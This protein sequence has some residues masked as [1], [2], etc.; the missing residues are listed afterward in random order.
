MVWNYIV[1]NK[2][3]LSGVIATVVM[4]VIGIWLGGKV[5]KKK[6]IKNVI[7]IKNS[8]VEKNE[9]DNAKYTFNG[10]SQYN[11]ADV[12][13]INNDFRKLGDENDEI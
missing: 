13:N 12:I 8:K 5:I 11:R 4:G 7:K 1:E 10:N 6:K 3:W 9:I 2:E